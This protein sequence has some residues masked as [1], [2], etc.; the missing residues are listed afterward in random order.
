MQSGDGLIKGKPDLV[1]KRNGKWVLLDYK[2]GSVHEEDE[3]SGRQQI[4]D[5]YRL[6]LQLYAYL[7][8]EAKGI[9]V[10][11][12]LLRTL[13]GVEHE[14]AVDEA[15]VQLAGTEARLLLSEFNS[16]VK[17]HEDPFD[18]AKPMPNI[19]DQ[20]I[21]GCAGCQFRPLCPS[22]RDFEKTVGSGER[23]PNDAWGEVISM[24]RMDGKVKVR[25]QN[26]NRVIGPSGAVSNPELEVNLKDST[27]RH[28]N[29]EG[30]EK[31]AYI[32]VYDYLM[33][34]MSACGEDGPRTCV[35][36]GQ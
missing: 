36:A 16:G 1:E 5:D 21:F 19:R 13:D 32:R 11:K 30:I 33:F 14:V 2:S 31:G 34:R 18:L 23:W 15:S 8:R 10:S 7:I 25:I 28:P 6:Q 4:K 9:C 29:L 35:Y 12:A 3:E 24:E 22:Y 27:D 17:G 26:Q 20:K